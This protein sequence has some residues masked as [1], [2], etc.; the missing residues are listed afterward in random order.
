MWRKTRELEDCNKLAPEKPWLS[1]HVHTECS[2]GPP[3]DDFE[4]LGS[5]GTYKTSINKRLLH[6]Q[7]LYKRP[8]RQLTADRLLWPC[9]HTGKTVVGAKCVR[10]A[11]ITSSGLQEKQ[12]RAH[13]VNKHDACAR[14]RPDYRNIDRTVRL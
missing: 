3:D 5:Q 10:S 1:A 9:W 2:T 8:A 6:K 14:I 4:S 7:P 13:R 11:Y 12:M